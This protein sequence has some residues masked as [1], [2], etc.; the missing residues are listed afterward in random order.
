MR[1]VAPGPTDT[2]AADATMQPDDCGLQRLDPAHPSEASSAGSPSSGASPAQRR[3]PGAANATNHREA[4][5]T[6]DPSDL[7]TAHAEDLIARLHGWA[8]QL[9]QRESELNAGIARQET[10]ERSFRLWA[11]Q[12]REQLERLEREA[13]RLRERL[14]RHARRLAIAQT[15]R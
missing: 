3:R 11:G 9:D 12:Q 4:A 10:R 7:L 1:P 2:A 8:A 5:P 6:Q 15:A 13:L 14:Q